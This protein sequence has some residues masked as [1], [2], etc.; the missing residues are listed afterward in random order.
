MKK[1]LFTA[2]IG[3]ALSGCEN[4][5]GMSGGMSPGQRI[6]VK[7]Q[8]V[9]ARAQACVDQGLRPGSRKFKLCFDRSAER[10]VTNAPAPKRK[11]YEPATR[12]A[13]N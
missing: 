9:E 3:L 8:T 4:M 5:G 10:A 7:N 12:Q 1:L 11:P 6:N 13:E 2:V